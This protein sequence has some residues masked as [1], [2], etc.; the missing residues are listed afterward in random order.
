MTDVSCPNCNCTACVEARSLKVSDISCY[1]CKHCTNGYFHLLC[2]HLP[3]LPQVLRQSKQH[4]KHNNPDADKALVMSVTV[5]HFPLYVCP[6]TNAAFVLPSSSPVTAARLVLL[7]HAAGPSQHC[8]LMCL[9][10]P[11]ISVGL[12][13]R[14]SAALSWCQSCQK[15]SSPGLWSKTNDAQPAHCQT[16][17]L[18]C[19]NMHCP[20]FNGNWAACFR[21]ECAGHKVFLST[22]VCLAFG[23]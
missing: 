1:P 14:S 19:Q 7:R 18:A 6:L 2:C 5:Q 15:G 17:L 23:T 4:S 16:R 8:L 9:M 21:G 20:V 3:M 10:T 12:S 22:C 11:A 13:L